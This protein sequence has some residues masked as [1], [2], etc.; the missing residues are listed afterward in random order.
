[1]VGRVVLLLIMTTFSFSSFGEE[2]FRGSVVLKSKSVLR[3]EISVKH[4]YDVVFFRVADQVSVIPAF[5]IAY[6]SLYDEESEIQRRFVSL[7]IGIGAA[8]SH[9]FFELLVDGEVTILRRQLSLWYSLHLDM[10]EYEYYVLFDEEIHGLHKFRKNVY[11]RLISKTEGA[12]ASYVRANNLSTKALDD[13]L[14]MTT[15]YNTYVTSNH[16]IAKNEIQP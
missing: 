4:G 2:W 7:A 9:Q 5:K 8:R 15:Y 10:T 6:L 3:G 16:L 14:E 11:P 12:L 1:M 13:I